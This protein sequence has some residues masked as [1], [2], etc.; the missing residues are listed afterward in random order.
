MACA[1]WL[2][3]L[4][5]TGA[6]HRDIGGEELASSSL[7]GFCHSRKAEPFGGYDE[8]G[9]SVRIAKHAGEAAAINV[10]C[11]KNFAAIVYTYALSVWDIGVPDRILSIDTDAVGSTVAEVG[12]YA[13]V[14]Q[15]SIGVD[16]ECCKAVGMGTR[17]RSVW[18][19]RG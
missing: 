17:P 2:P 4:W 13:A 6:R 16:I 8:E 19:C 11:F 1:S 5:P 3:A 15:A 12:P 9:L 18:S 14:G 10:D 7:Q